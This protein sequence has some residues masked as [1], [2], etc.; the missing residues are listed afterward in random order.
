MLLLTLALLAGPVSTEIA[1]P[2]QPAPLHG[3]LLAP[4][5]ASAV[6]VILPGS[7]PTDRDGNS[8]LGISSAS[9]RLLAE[10]LASQGIATVRIDK[11]G[12]GASAAAGGPEI[13]LRFDANVADARA[14]AAEA[15]ARAD[16]PCAWLIGHSEGALV[17][18]KA[19]E[20]GRRR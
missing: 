13:E 2:A 10:G 12:V 9:Y 17:A 15:A 5:N 4:E 19:V 8:R 6:A 7:G 16:K 1:L 14:W 11:R 20:G 18:L 3:T